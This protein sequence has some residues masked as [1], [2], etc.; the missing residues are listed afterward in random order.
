MTF[1]VLLQDLLGLLIPVFPGLTVMWLG[2]LVYAIMQ[3]IGGKMTW[4]DWLLFALSPC[5]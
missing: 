2:T 4:V 1:F 5:S 3:A